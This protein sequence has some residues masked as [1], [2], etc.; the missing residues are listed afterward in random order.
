MTKIIVG[1]GQAGGWSAV[2]MRQ[3]GYTGRILLI[4][5]EQWRPYE[6]PPLSKAIL[7]DEPEPPITHFHCQERYVELDI[8]LLLGVSVAE[9]DAVKQRIRLADGVILNYDQLLLTVGGQ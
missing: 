6:R 2:A 7:T 9:I 4:G 3:A 1:A 8:E 5:D